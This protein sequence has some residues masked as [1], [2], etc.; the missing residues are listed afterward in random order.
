M[1]EENNS[2]SLARLL[3]PY[4]LVGGVAKAGHKS[5]SGS[6]PQKSNNLHTRP[7]APAA[8]RDQSTGNTLFQ[9]TSA[10]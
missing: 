2:E 6:H 4:A 1:E 5:C 10:F 8:Q 3:K 9:P 7:I